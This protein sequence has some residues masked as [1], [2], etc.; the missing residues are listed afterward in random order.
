MKSALNSW[1]PQAVAQ[2]AEPRHQRVW[3]IIV[4]VFGDMAQGPGD[5][6]SGGTLNRIIGPMGI[7]PEAIRVAIHRLR[8]DGWLQS[9]R[10]GRESRHFLTE[11][12]RR[13]SAAVTPR[14]Y[15]RHPRISDDW[16]VLIAADAPGIDDLGELV[17]SENFIAVSRSVAIG[18][19]RPPTDRDNLMVFRADP[20]TVPEWF[21][22]R[23]FPPELEQACRT[24]LEDSNT[25]RNLLPL[26]SRPTPLQTAVLRTLV[27]HRWRR[28]ALRHPDL[29]PQ[30]QP[31]GWPGDACREAVFS[32][33]DRLPRPSLAQLEKP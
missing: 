16:H 8:K 26:R 13:Q 3:S 6:L 32:L 14:I 18:P 9:E 19:G 4:T 2:L 22:D 28:V 29:P 11:F 12:G 27:V 33:L 30:Y 5:R 17:L 25:V 7:R 23:L 21:R 10:S 1:F 15:T 20:V 31:P 24:L